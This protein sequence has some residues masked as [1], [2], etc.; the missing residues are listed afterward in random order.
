MRLIYWLASYP[1]SGNTWLRLFLANYCAE[2]HA[3]IGIN[4]MGGAMAASRELFEDYAGL[5]T[6]ELTLA[7]IERY[8][9]RVYAALAARLV[10]PLFLKTHDACTCNAVGEWLFPPEATAGVIYLVR[11]PLDVAVSLA[12]HAGIPPEQAV[13]RLCNPAYVLSNPGDRLGDQLP[14]RLFDW[15]GHGRSWLNQDSLPVHLVRYEDLW[16]HPTETFGDLIRFAGLPSEPGRLQRALA[17]TRFERLQAQE[18]AEGF[19]ER[20]PLSTRPF[21]GLG[22]AGGWRAELNPDLVRQLINA[23]RAMMRRLGYLTEY[24]EPVY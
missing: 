11:N 5:D 12:H 1:K 20:R 4:Q 16:A 19:V 21:F 24:G 15:S 3:L 6:S 17:A 8:R 9:P 18:A 7:E 2:E 23:H 10:A 22:R 14:Q 13:N